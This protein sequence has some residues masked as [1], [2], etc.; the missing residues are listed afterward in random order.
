MRGTGAS[1]GEGRGREPIE[2]ALR[3][4]EKM[5]VIVRRTQTTEE[6]VIQCHDK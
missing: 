6:L 3:G 5:I 2:L 1:P 4:R